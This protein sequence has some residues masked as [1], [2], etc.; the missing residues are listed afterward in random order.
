VGNTNA[1]Q[2][3]AVTST[4]TGTCSNPAGANH[5]NNP[6]EPFTEQE[7]NTTTNTLLPSRNGRILIPEISEEATTTEEFLA[8]FECPNPQWEATVTSSAVSFV[9]TVTFAGFDE[10]FILI[11]G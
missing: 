1:T 3:L 2:T 6:I 10:P 5:P 8:T 9:Y 7:T 4:F 11:T